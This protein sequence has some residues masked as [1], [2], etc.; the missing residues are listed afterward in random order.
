MDGGKKVWVSHP[1]EGF[2]L[3][4]IVDIAADSI[5]VEPFDAPGSVSNY[6]LFIILLLLCKCFI[7]KIIYWLS[8]S[9]VKFYFLKYIFAGILLRSK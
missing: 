9:Y 2:K 4:R 8:E 7:M 5:T 6:L 3:G 1:I